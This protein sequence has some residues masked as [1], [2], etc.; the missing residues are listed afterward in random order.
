MASGKMS[1]SDFLANTKSGINSNGI[2]IGTYVYVETSAGLQ[3]L[4]FYPEAEQVAMVA[5]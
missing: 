3:I 4:A 2:F 5:P 1:L